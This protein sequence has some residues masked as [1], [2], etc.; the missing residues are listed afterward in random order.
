MRPNIAPRGPDVELVSRESHS[1]AVPPLRESMPAKG[2]PHL[3]ERTNISRLLAALLRQKWII[4]LGLL[5]GMVVGAAIWMFTTPRF[6]ATAKLLIANQVHVGGDTYPGQSSID[7]V[8]VDTQ[9]EVIRSDQIIR[10]A[11]ARLA[12]DERAQLQH[13]L[14]MQRQ[15]SLFG[16]GPRREDP[17]LELE[18]VRQ[19]LSVSRL[20]RTYVLEARYISA[21]PK[22]AATMANAVVQEF[23]DGQIRAQDDSSRV[24][25]NALRQREAELSRDIAEAE[26][27]SMGGRRASGPPEESIVQRRE[28]DAK[29]ESLRRELTGITQQLSSALQVAMMTGAGARILVAATESAS[30]AQPRLMV[31]A[32]MSILG[33]LIL[34]GVIAALREGM[35]QTFRTSASVGDELGVPCLGLLPGS[36]HMHRQSGDGKLARSSLDAVTPVPAAFSIAYEFPLSRMADAVRATRLAASAGMD[37]AVIGVTSALPG[38]GKTHFAANMAF[39]LAAE[40]NSVLLVDADVRRRGLSLQLAPKAANG[41]LDVI[42]TGRPVNL[43][44]CV[45]TEKVTNLSFLPTG[46]AHRERLSQ[47]LS[48]AGLQAF[49]ASV[50]GHYNFV[51][52]DMPSTGLVADSRSL[53]AT[54][55]TFVLVVRWGQTRIGIVA[56]HLSDNERLRQG[57]AGV[58][59]SNV[60]LRR[61][62]AYETEDEARAA[63]YDAYFEE[64]QCKAKRQ[65]HVI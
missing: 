30:P 58:V 54:L 48:V 41:L 22:L 52:V 65:S 37:T 14:A 61:M 45:L 12:P 7:S 63:V 36:G 1:G 24:I 28:L 8:R 38:E 35:D 40:G 19:N 13:D 6:S 21:A 25:V 56:R 9:V 53:M 3:P 43:S 39:L 2:I 55:D 27:A 33:G 16:P 64:P 4:L 44:S 11:L 29:V 60:D 51:I 46:S 10:L 34:G 23:I 20:E 57:L 18:T 32:V 59:L 62:A 15:R 26:R 5:S 50:R 17:Q 47:D 42:D 49:L 31:V